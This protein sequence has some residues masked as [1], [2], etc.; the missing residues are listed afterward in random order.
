MN[1]FADVSS[2]SLMGYEQMNYGQF[3]EIQ[4]SYFTLR[5]SFGESH[6]VSGP[7]HSHLNMDAIIA[8]DGNPPGAH[9]PIQAAQRGFVPIQCNCIGS[10]REKSEKVG[11][12]RTV[13]L[14]LTHMLDFANVFSASLMG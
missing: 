12:S 7:E 14:F 3:T 11:L 5:F 9:L 10:G 4:R 1:D 6:G 2:P 8:N 13:S